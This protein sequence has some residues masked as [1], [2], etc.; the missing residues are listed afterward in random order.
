MRSSPRL[1]FFAILSGLVIASAP[2]WA[3][4]CPYDMSCN[5]DDSLVSDI[6]SAAWDCHSIVKNDNHVGYNGGGDYIQTKNPTQTPITNVWV[7]YKS[8]SP[9][10]TRRLYLYASDAGE[11]RVTAEDKQFFVA[12][13]GTKTTT[14]MVFSASN[15]IRSLK[16]IAN[17]SS[18]TWVIYA[19]TVYTVD[20]PPSLGPVADQTIGSDN[21]IEHLPLLAVSTVPGDVLSVSVSTADA[22]PAASYGVFSENSDWFFRFSPST[23]GVT[24]GQFTFTAS[25]TGIGGTTNVSFAVTVTE[26]VV[27]TPPTIDAIDDQAVLARRR[28]TVPFTVREADGDSVFTNVICRTA[29]VEGSYGRD[30]AGAFFFEPTLADALLGTIDF[31][32][33]ATDSD[34]M[35]GYE[36]FSVSITVGSPPDI[37]SIAPQTIAYGG[38]NQVTLVL[39]PTDNDDIT[40]TNVAVKTETLVP[41]GEHTYSNL[42]FRFVPAA[43]DIGQ[44]FTFLAT[45]TDF[46]GT[47]SNEFSVTVG[48][49]KPVL[50][51]C[52][53]DQWTPTSFKADLEALVPGAQEYR[54]KYEYKNQ[55]GETVPVVIEGIRTWPVEVENAPSTNLT[56]YVQA[57]TGTVASAWSSGKKMELNTWLPYVPAIRM[58]KDSGGVYTQDFDTLIKSGTGK[59]YDGRTLPGWHTCW[60]GRTITDTSV[61]Y[62]AF[63]Y[64]NNLSHQ[65]FFS[66]ATDGENSGKRAFGMRNDARDAYAQIGIAFTNECRYAVTNVFIS[67]TATQ[68]RDAA[69]E[70]WLRVQYAKTDAVRSL[71]HAEW[72]EGQ[73]WKAASALDFKAPKQNKAQA[74]QPKPAS[75]FRSGNIAL[76]GEDAIQ[77]GEV[78]LIQWWM[79]ET[80]KGAPLGI[81]DLTVSWECAWP[82]HTVIYLR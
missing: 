22:L 19:I 76:T 12:K 20:P 42:V 78:L 25:A 71:N 3:E 81:D 2:G 35:V 7:Q 24:S 41:E 58:I 50:K 43:A 8:S 44:T 51:H 72:P 45:A 68:F 46:D 61:N 65:G 15:D 67:F 14:N 38:T 52:P 9:D 82:H 18:G 29:N 26:G 30:A 31:R 53:V 37:V 27:K 39:M 69:G 49:A 62:E 13:G 73:T 23:A 57:Y 47:S 80:D 6:A 21:T 77:P 55:Q 74:I 33:E 63:G 56:Y 34:D 40:Y 70:S 11:A 48:L 66:F 4:V 54:L 32:I 10:A 17:G 1:S 64:T 36:D 79:D 28:L 75:E 16:L 5:G 60:Y 59:W